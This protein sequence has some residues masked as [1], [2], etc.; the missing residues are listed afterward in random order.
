MKLNS[1]VTKGIV[2]LLLALCLYLLMPTQIKLINDDK[3]NARTFPTVLICGMVICSLLEIIGGLIAKKKEYWVVS[4]ESL[5][6]LVDPVCML[7]IILAYV[8]L[9]PRIGFLISSLVCCCGAMAFLKC[10]KVS[11]YA[12]VIAFAVAVCFIFTKVLHVP[13]P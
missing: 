11:Y 3:I 7:L 4:K 8:L 1:K 6:Q 9:I 12:I 10:K 13:L 2:F 5:K